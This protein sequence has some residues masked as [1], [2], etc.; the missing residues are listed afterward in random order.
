MALKPYIFSGQGFSLQRDKNRFV[1]PSQFRSTLKESSGRAVVCLAKHDRWT[2]LTG[3]GLSRVDGFA[4]QIEHEQEIALKAG[5]D[6]DP[7]KRAMRLYGFHEVPFDGSG[8]FTLPEPLQTTGKIDGE[9]YFHSAG[10]FF[11]VWNPHE[12]AR[13]EGEEW[14]YEKAICDSLAKAERAKAKKK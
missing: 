3:F 7:D 5:K 11:T 1:L 8:R 9:L 13:M 10:Q 4:A 14:D 6:Y 2:C 12:L